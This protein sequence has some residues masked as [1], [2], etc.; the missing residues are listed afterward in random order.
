MKLTLQ[1]VKSFTVGALEVTE[2]N[3]CFHFSRFTESQ[4]LAFG[5]LEDLFYTRACATT[6]C[7]L[8]FHT[9]AKC[10]LVE[11]ITQGKYEVLVDG[12]QTFFVQSPERRKYAVTLPGRDAHVTILL[13]HHSCGV[14]GT[15]YLDEGSYA[16]PHSFDRKMLFMGDS[17][18]QGWA[19]Q[20]DSLCYAHI[21]AQHF[22]A[23]SLNWA[24]GGAYFSD[25]AI[26]D[27]GYDPDIVVVAYGTNDYTYYP[28]REA[29][30]QA[31][32]DSLK[33]VKAY[34]GSK[35][36]FC[37]SPIWRADGDVLRPAG[38][39]DDCREF[40]I[41]EIEANGFIHLD[42]YAL[43]PHDTAYFEDGRLHPNDLGFSIYARNL[44]RMMEPLIRK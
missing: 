10:M 28:S 19:S 32:R 42:G 27:A 3:G 14:L 22:N 35:Q 33:K 7:R 39:L 31:C 8:E 40:L 12:L 34:Y 13:P 23:E 26:S 11:F 37:I 9:N 6:G 36:V 41:Q 4:K 24:V 2:E 38:T 17:I 44:I 18:T 20:H 25:P 43:H 1:Q 21:V 30:Q 29:M 5:A 16:R 15:V